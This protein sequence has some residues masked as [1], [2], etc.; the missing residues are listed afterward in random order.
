MEGTEE[1]E[2]DGHA[3][4]SQV[5][6]N[7]VIKEYI[8]EKL[9]GILVATVV[10]AK[11]VH[12]AQAVAHAVPEAVAHAVA[13]AAAHRHQSRLPAAATAPRWTPC[14]TVSASFF[15]ILK[16]EITES[17][18]RAP[19]QLCVS[20]HNPVDPDSVPHRGYRWNRTPGAAS[21]TSRFP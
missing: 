11:G 3:I 15:S 7:V 5:R 21:D 13:K 8:I 14:G 18:R 16:I 19:N 6:C 10:A 4:Y 17:C 9:K 20:V 1:E 12:V 2:K